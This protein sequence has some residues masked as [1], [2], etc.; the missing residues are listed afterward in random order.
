M[1]LKGKAA[2]PLQE[3]WC[4]CAEPEAKGPEVKV[5]RSIVFIVEIILYFYRVKHI[6][7]L[8]ACIF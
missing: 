3:I 7:S 8:L 1:F 2:L 6:Y 4:Q 5:K